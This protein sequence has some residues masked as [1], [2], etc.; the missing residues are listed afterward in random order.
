MSAKRPLLSLSRP[1][2]IANPPILQTATFKK[3]FTF[4]I[5]ASHVACLLHETYTGDLLGT[6]RYMA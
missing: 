2:I 4:M 3:P 6:Y 1:Y 5:D